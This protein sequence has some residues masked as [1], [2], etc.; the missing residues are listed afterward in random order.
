M[1]CGNCSFTLRGT[2]F[3]SST[4]PTHGANARSL[5]VTPE[6]TIPKALW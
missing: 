3:F 5:P 1:S 2:F 6:A 4:S